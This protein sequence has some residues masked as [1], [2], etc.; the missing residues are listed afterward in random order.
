MGAEDEVSLVLDR[1]YYPTRHYEDIS[2]PAG[3]YLSLRICI[4][5]A[6]GQNWW[7][8]LYP[9]V[10]LEA[11]TSKKTL[12]QAGFSDSQIHLVTNEGG[13][14]YKIKFKILQTVSSWMDALSSKKSS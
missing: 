12:S 14:R 3:N 5:Q 11:C 1:E 13:V 7:C 9:P 8:V 6:E 10:C 2:L 4:G